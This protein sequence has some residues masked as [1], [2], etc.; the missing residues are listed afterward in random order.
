MRSDARSWPDVAA[1]AE[2]G[3][4]PFARDPL[5]KTG[6]QWS[7]RSEGLVVNYVGLP[8]APGSGP[9][10]LILVQEPDPVTGEKA[11]PPSA[12]ATVD[13]E[14]QLLAD[15]TLLHVSYWKTTAQS[16][17]R[18]IIGDPALA[19]WTQIRVTSPL[20]EM[21]QWRDRTVRDS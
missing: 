3:I 11:P 13:E 7:V 15:G 18:G 9:A 1:L 19:G 12:P 21:E 20:K 2:A 4:P 17:R 5:D 6:L 10:Y 16:V 8:S 14:H